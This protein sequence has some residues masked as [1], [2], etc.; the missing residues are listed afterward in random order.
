MEPTSS[1]SSSAS[2]PSSPPSS[3]T[4]RTA[5]PVCDSGVQSAVRCASF[6]SARSDH[7]FILG[8]SGGV[9]VE[10]LPSG[11]LS[12]RLGFASGPRGV[13]CR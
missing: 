4:S 11:S 9:A 1:S 3:G 8:H 5:G 2:S 12:I 10:A 13:C 7:V 6:F